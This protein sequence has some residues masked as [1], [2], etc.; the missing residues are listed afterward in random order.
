MTEKLACH[1]RMQ[2]ATVLIGF[3]KTTMLPFASANFFIAQVIAH[4]DQ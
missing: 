1:L 3:V 2:E 4:D